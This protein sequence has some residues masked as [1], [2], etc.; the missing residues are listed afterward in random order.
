M[1]RSTCA[2]N[3]RSL[4]LEYPRR[5]N[6]PP[7]S[8]RRGGELQFL[9]GGFFPSRRGAMTPEHQQSTLVPF[10][11]SRIAP[12]QEHIDRAIEDLLAAVPQPHQPAP[13]ARR[14]VIARHT[15]V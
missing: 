7:T 2:S 8:G 1:P 6:V 10:E 12:L 4:R 11:R 14:R 9:T 13:D 15:A 3:D 5:R